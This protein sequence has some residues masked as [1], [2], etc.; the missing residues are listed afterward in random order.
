MQRQVPSE[1]ILPRR[2]SSKHNSGGDS[3]GQSSSIAMA[4]A[5]RRSSAAARKE[6]LRADFLILP[7]LAETSPSKGRLHAVP[8]CM[9]ECPSAMSPTPGGFA[10]TYFVA[11]SARSMN[12]AEQPPKACFAWVRLRPRGAL[13]TPGSI[14]EAR[15]RARVRT[16][17]PH[18]MRAPSARWPARVRPR[19]R[20]GKAR[21]AAGRTPPRAFP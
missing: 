13:S 11:P 18:L 3:R 7:G 1:R 12:A 4:R 19:A 15:Y 9:W 6:G 5:K 17:L 10:D 16:R 8:L 2:R 14:P 20:S 21:S